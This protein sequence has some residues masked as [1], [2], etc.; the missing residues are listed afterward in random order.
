MFQ[1]WAAYVL[2]F[3]NYG[4]YD[5]IRGAWKAYGQTTA[6]CAGIG[7]LIWALCMVALGIFCYACMRRVT[8]AQTYNIELVDASKPDMPQSETMSPSSQGHVTRPYYG[9]GPTFQLFM[10]P[11]SGVVGME[12][13]AATPDHT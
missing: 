5:S 9:G 2:S 11:I 1:S 8:S 12:R 7:A 10:T 3:D 4:L 6:A 13:P